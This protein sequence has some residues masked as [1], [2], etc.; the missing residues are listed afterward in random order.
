MAKTRLVL[1][2]VCIVLILWYVYETRGP[3][4]SGDGRNNATELACEMA[5]AF[6]NEANSEELCANL[7]ASQTEYNELEAQ[8]GWDGQQCQLAVDACGVKV[9]LTKPNAGKR[10]SLF[11]I[12]IAIFVAALVYMYINRPTAKV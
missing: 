6:C 11:D 8:C 7:T 4:K 1:G 12:F 3:P 2:V 5:E 10:V 9:R